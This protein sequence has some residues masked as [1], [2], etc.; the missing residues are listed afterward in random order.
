MAVRNREHRLGNATSRRATADAFPE[1]RAAT[2]WRRRP[3]GTDFAPP[4]G[5]DASPRHE[6]QGRI[7]AGSPQVGVE[8]FDQLGGDGLL[9]GGFL[10]E[11]ERR[12]GL[13]VDVLGLEEDVHLPGEPVNLVGAAVRR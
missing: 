3:I 7:P 1:R 8:V 4:S 13:A 10:E 6:A 5:L 9:A 12:G 11:Q 2:W